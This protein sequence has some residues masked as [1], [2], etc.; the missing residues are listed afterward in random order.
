MIVLI[1][2]QS[3]AAGFLFGLIF[4]GWYED[5]LHDREDPFQEREP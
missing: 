5:R 3:L 1:S 2:I 4:A